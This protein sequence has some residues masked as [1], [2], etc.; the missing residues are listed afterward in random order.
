MDNYEEEKKQAKQVLLNEYFG[1]GNNGYPQENAKLDKKFH[2][3][4]S[5]GL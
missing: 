1:L 4:Y 2:F 5:Q 3:D